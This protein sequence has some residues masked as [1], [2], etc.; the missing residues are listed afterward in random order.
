MIY[1]TN[2]K[3][4]FL[5]LNHQMTNRAKTLNEWQNSGVKDW[6]EYVCVQRSFNVVWRVIF[7]H[8]VEGC[9]VGEE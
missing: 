1:N 7:N 2:S 4:F 5:N 9:S 6:Y 3:Y 8:I